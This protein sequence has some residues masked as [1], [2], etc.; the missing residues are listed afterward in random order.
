M[1]G[2]K[3][4]DRSGLILFL[5]ILSLFMCG[6]LGV[7]AWIM[8]GS[9]LRKIRK[10]Y[11]PPDKIGILKTG[12]VLGIIG[13]VIFFAVIVSGAAMLQ[14]QFGELPGMF[15]YTPLAADQAAFVGEWSGKKGTLIKIYSDGR[16]DF[17]SAKASIAGGRVNIKGESLSIRILGFARTW[18]IDVRPHTENGKWSMQLDGETFVKKSEGHLII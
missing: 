11:L 13:T 1:K 3:Y 17:R 8:A 12:R 15:R 10:G 9:D 16:G 2:N 4:H 14:K 18:H 6:P 5:G 7:A